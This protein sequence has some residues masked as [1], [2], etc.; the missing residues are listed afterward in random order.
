MGARSTSLAIRSWIAAA[1]V[2]GLY[3]ATTWALGGNPG[4][5]RTIVTT[6]HHSDELHR[7]VSGITVSRGVWEVSDGGLYDLSLAGPAGSAC[8]IDGIPAVDADPDD[9]GARTRTVWLPAGFHG[10]EIRQAID[11]S[12]PPA[13]LAAA[14]TGRPLRPLA[15]TA[16]APKNPRLHVAVRM[17]REVLGWTT[18]V[19]LAVAIGTSFMALC[20]WWNRRVP[21]RTVER[22]AARSAGR[23]R[24]W[25]ARAGGCR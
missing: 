24:L 1:A 17:L 9:S 14:R 10:V 2:T 11:P 3:V 20:R 12:S 5:V 7:S 6:T 4:L 22:S 16:K 25:L 15:L 19:A 23:R 13:A 21:R 8:T 18:I